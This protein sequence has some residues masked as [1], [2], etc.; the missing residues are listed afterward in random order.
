[1]GLV[2]LGY[3]FFVTA[4]FV[5]FNYRLYLASWAEVSGLVL[6]DFGYHFCL[7]LR[8][9]SLCTDDGSNPVSQW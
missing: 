1:M 7:S 2:R 3:G 4:V 6:I 8:S 9:S 5:G